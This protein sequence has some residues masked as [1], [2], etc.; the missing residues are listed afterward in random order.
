MASQGHHTLY[1]QCINT[2]KHQ[3]TKHAMRKQ[4]IRLRTK[5]APRRGALRSAHDRAALLGSTVRE[6]GTARR[7]AAAQTA[8]V[9]YRASADGFRPSLGSSWEQKLDEKTEKSCQAQTNGWSGG[10]P[11]RGSLRG[12]A[13][14][15]GGLMA[16]VCGGVEWLGAP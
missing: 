13:G 8:A 2:C 1:M 12:R 3:H 10:G 4:M 7:N 14:G 16:G 15:L 5:T 9:P 11:G 6:I